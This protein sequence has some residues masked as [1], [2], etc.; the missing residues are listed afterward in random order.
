MD[1]PGSSGFSVTV[2]EDNATLKKY[3]SFRGTEPSSIWE[4]WATDLNAVL[5]SGLAQSQTI[6]MVNWTLR[7]ITPENAPVVQYAQGASSAD[8][9]LIDSGLGLGNGAL[10][11]TGPVVVDG[12]SLGGHLA[13]VFTRL[14]NDRVANTFTYNGLGVGPLFPE[15]LL[16]NIGNSISQIGTNTWQ[17]AKQTNFYAT[18]GT[19]AT[20]KAGP[21]STAP[22][23][24][25]ASPPSPAATSGPAPT[26]DI[27]TSP[28][29][30]L[31][32]APPCSSTAC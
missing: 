13:T 25:A 17:D 22:Y 24:P 23:S 18:Q 10:Y 31:P 11:N 15:T 30:T 12:H 29:A 19:T 9:V 26:V 4:Y 27:P 28:R 21:R 32:P 6:A 20:A 14:F 1:R 3:V 7:A 2:F 16:Q 8:G 5:Y